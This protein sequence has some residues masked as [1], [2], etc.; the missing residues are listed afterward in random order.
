MF[1]NNAFAQAP[2][3]ATSGGDLFSLLVPFALIFVVMYFLIIRP[4]SKRMKMHKELISSLRRGDI[5]VTSGGLVGKIHRVVDDSDVI[6]ELTENIRITHQRQ[7]IVEIRAKTETLPS[8]DNEEEE[9]VKKAKKKT[10]TKKRA[11]A[12]KSSTS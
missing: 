12:K 9:P 6:I 2:A 11:P 8:D 1:I 7:M 5:V 3:G 10:T 4:Q